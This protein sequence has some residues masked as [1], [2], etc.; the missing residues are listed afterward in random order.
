MPLYYFACVACKKE[1]R[2]L[3]N[4]SAEAKEKA[5]QCECGGL[6]SRSPRAPGIK[7]VETI[8]NGFMS[9][10]VERL[11]DATRLYRERADADTRKDDD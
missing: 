5:G 7:A 8:D 6:Y 1:V 4:N 2:K 3:A 10:K 11:V 9:R